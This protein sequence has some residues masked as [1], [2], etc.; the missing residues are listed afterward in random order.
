MTFLEILEQPRQLWRQHTIVLVLLLALIGGAVV[1]PSDLPGYHAA[2]YDGA[3][4]PLVTGTED[5]G[6]HLNTLLALAVPLMARDPAGFRQ[7]AVITL[8]GILATHG[9]KRLLDGLVIGATRLGERPHSPDSQHNMPSGHSALA[10]SVVWFLGRRYSW[11]LA[12]ITVPITL[13]TMYAR[14]MLNA[15]T[16]SAVI[17]GCLIGLVIAALFT[18]Q[19]QR[20]RKA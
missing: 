17:A 16:F 4:D 5:Y 14:V 11:W 18:T 10:S 2:P 15:H 3:Q 9:P 1:Y 6:R 12:L 7:L 19:R 13:L 20:A 8:A